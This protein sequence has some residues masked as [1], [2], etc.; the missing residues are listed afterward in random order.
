MVTKG[1]GRR[2]QGRRYR[3]TVQ[4]S[5]SAKIDGETG[6]S[7]FNTKEW[8]RTRCGAEET[9]DRHS[10]LATPLFGE[11]KKDI[12]VVGSHDGYL[13]MYCPSSQW[14]DETK[15]SSNYKSTDQMIETRIGDCI[16]DM[17]TGKFVS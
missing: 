8:W 1:V 9:F 14:N 6:M 4:F 13:R 17:K 2:R 10:L 12:L 5:F 7:L 3:A 11:D 16:V 15:S